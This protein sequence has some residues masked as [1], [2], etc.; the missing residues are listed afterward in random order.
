MDYGHKQTE[1]MLAALEQKIA[2]IYSE[3][4]EELKE[5]IEKYFAQFKKRDEHQLELL[6]AGKITEEQYK[7]WRLAQIGRGERFK[8]LQQKV[9]ER[10]TEANKTAVAYV[11]D[12][13]PG[14]Y[15]LNRNYAA[16][17]I[18]RVGANV[19]FALWDEQTVRRLIVEE[20]EV[21]P[22]YPPK[23]AL[24]RGIDLA[25][26][27]RQISASITSAI[28][29]GK[30][31]GKIA[32]DLEARM[33]GMSRASAIRAAR[34]ATTGAQNAGRYD[35]YKAAQKMGI[36]LEAEWLATLDNR[37]RHSHA[38]L[39][40]KR[41]EIDVPFEV[42]GKE[43]L[44][45]GHALA[46]GELVYNCRC[47]I[48]AHVKGVDTSDAV[49]RARDPETV[50]S[51]VVEDMTYQEWEAWKKKEN[52]A[53][54]DAFM[55]KEKNASADKKQYEKYK[56]VLKGKAGKTIDEFTQMKYNNTEK[57]GFLKLDYARRSKLQ[58]HPETALPNAEKAKAPDE[59]FTKY[60]FNP[61]NKKGWAKGQAL[62]SRLGYSAENWEQLKKEILRGA[63]IYPANSKGNNGYGEIYEQRM[64]LYGTKN[65]PANVI[66]GWIVKED[67]SVS[68]TSA[69]IKEVK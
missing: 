63:K 24:N 32:T 12:A 5:T 66:V 48:I 62:S 7:Q 40:G 51:V 64:V 18:E 19:D 11:N 67:G 35:T 47:T 6:K 26:G 44:F 29:Q 45:P 54:W 31:I 33:T 22:Y 17:E 42:D 46:V 2:G 59:K 8:A 23:K 69:Y 9:A 27:K 56:A 65:T 39:D 58:N 1:K 49:R 20:P 34:T 60:L 16:Y 37:T 36:E 57:W 55:K 3:A 53:A 4:S 61:E 28:L 25:W 21:M 68:M 41:S 10:Y 13:T 52:P 38:M 50:E 15:S 30:S 43:I 14:V